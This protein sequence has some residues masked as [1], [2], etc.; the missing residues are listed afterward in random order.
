ME[1]GTGQGEKEIL[2]ET[3]KRDAGTMTAEKSTP[4]QGTE[5]GGRGELGRE[6]HKGRQ[7]E[8]KYWALDTQEGQG[9]GVTRT[10]SRKR[11]GEGLRRRGRHGQ[12]GEGERATCARGGC[13]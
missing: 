7:L 2:R 8:A 1:K 11:H 6:T 12:D 9:Q 4:R 3:Q 13:V 5:R 10:L